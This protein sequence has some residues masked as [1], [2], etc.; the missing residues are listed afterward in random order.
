M[1]TKQSNPKPL[2]LNLR[3]AALR[4]ACAGFHSWNTPDRRPAPQSTRSSSP[5]AI[6][7][8]LGLFGVVMMLA[9]AALPPLLRGQTAISPTLPSI[10]SGVFVVTNYGAIG[11][12][13]STNTDAIQAAITDASN[14]NGGGTIEIPYMPGTANVYLS[15]PIRLK[16]KMNLQVDAGVTLRMLPYGQYPNLNPLISAGSNPS[17]IEISG[18][19]T[20]DGQAT[21]AGWWNGMST[22]HRP[23][24]INLSHGA[25]IWIHNVTLTRSPKMHIVIGSGSSHDVTIE[26]VTIATD[27]SDSHNTDGIDLTGY[28][29]VVRDC[30]ISCGDDNIAI[31]STSANILVTN[32]DFGTGHGMSFGS[33]TGPGGISNVTV[34]NC[35]FNRT[36]NG[37]RIKSDNTSGGPVQDIHYLN[38]SMTNVN[39]GAIVIYGYYPSLSPKNTSPA[40][41]AA[42]PIAPVTSDTPVWHDIYFS[43]LTATVAGNA[44]AGILWGRTEMPLTNIVL[45]HVHITAANS[46]NVYNAQRVQL[47]DSTITTTSP[48]QPNLTYWNG[49]IIVSNRAPSAAPIS[50]GGLVGN[51]DSSLA[52]YRA[53]ASMS[54]SDAFGANPITLSG[55]ALTNS[56]HLTL[57]SSDT[58]NFVL[59]TNRTLVN[60]LGTLTLDST[61]NIMAGAGFTAANYTLFRS[62]GS[63]AGSPLLGTVP[64]GYDCRLDTNTVGEV[65]LIVT[66]AVP[67]PPSFDNVRWASNG[68][69]ELIFSGSGGVTNGS[70]SV[71]TSTNLALPLSQW[72]PIATNSFDDNGDF[73]FTSHAGGN[74]P[75]RYYRLRL[76]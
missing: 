4:I 19:G 31:T 56:G 60:V 38:L 21:Y 33:D 18:G 71:L 42:Q 57:G 47:L 23:Y 51:S 44:S 11:D 40:T 5:F 74:A 29:E 37:I 41:A 10:P 52:L 68:S 3:S 8:S 65:N 39:N 35:T 66:R 45:D 46:F 9:L 2:S 62:V 30:N 73:S 70:Y 25:R 20:I 32:C 36:D 6:G 63:L 12:G 72:A 26:K 48:G 67:R 13:V 59:G 64:N 24:L 43:N 14:A 7:R 53:N 17:D 50:L 1:R 61:L 54:G 28:N 69:G 49:G 34:I 58:I 22:S 55:S 75:E 16:N 76:P 15:G 27:S